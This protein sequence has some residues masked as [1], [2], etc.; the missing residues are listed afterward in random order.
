MSK[1]PQPEKQPKSRES[2]SVSPDDFAGKPPPTSRK[3]KFSANNQGDIRQQQL[4]QERYHFTQQQ[5][6][7]KQQQ[8]QL[9]QQCSPVNQQW[10]QQFIQ[11]QQGDG[12]TSAIQAE[13]MAHFATRRPNM[14]SNER[15]DELRELLRSQRVDIA[16]KA[17][18]EIEADSVEQA[19]DFAFLLSFERNC[20]LFRGQAR[21]WSPIPNFLRLSPEKR[22]TSK[23][24][25]KFKEWAA[26][27]GPLKSYS[28]D[29]K[30]LGAIGQHYGLETYLL[31][32]S[33][34]PR[35]AA[36]FATNTNLPLDDE[37]ACIYC[38]WSGGLAGAYHLA[39]S[40]MRHYE[41][42]PKVERVDV[43]GLYRMH[44][45]EGTFL[46]VNQDS[47]TSVYSLDVITFPR[48]GPIKTPTVE[49]I[50]PNNKSVVE[51]LVEE[52]FANE[53][54]SV[55]IHNS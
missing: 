30:K 50:Y 10:F 9:T 13:F 6:Q 15:S 3:K 34:N 53:P 24:W 5:P 38:L 26:R 40:F 28:T 51:R 31:D 39:P 45:Q 48:T 7:F 8:A 47:W 54:D 17:A 25:S 18:I 12:F 2:E 35:V 49:S 36:F 37:K 32:F 52:Y 23:R 41:I 43:E 1:K 16:S 29:P 21:T 20:D 19:I 44:A 4:H 33:F 14:L 22:M 42:F 27:Q 46:F 11:E 55:R